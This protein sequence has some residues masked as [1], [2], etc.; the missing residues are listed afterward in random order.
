MGNYSRSPAQF[1]LRLMRRNEFDIHAVSHCIIDSVALSSIGDE[2]DFCIQGTDRTN[3]LLQNRM[4]SPIIAK[5]FLFH[6]N[7]VKKKKF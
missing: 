1:P 2:E 5:S 7:N 4:T 6:K 3:F